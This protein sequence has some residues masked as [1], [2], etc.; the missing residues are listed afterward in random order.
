[1]MSS[2]AI[3]S[4]GDTPPLRTCSTANQKAPPAPSRTVPKSQGRGGRVLDT[5]ERFMFGHRRAL[6]ALCVLL[7]VVAAWVASTLKFDTEPERKL[8]S[9]HPYARTAPEFRDR[10]ACLNPLQIVV[11]T[12]KGT[13]WNVAFLRKLYEV[14]QEV[15]FLPGISPES[16]ASLWTPNTLV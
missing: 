8:P 14:T 12:E 11:E 16:V 6:L 7:T 9:D 5:V 4:A 2:I 1:M 10:I 3:D 13:I 15:G